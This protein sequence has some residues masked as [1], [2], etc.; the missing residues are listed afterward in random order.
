MIQMVTVQKRTDERHNI[1]ISVEKT[2][3]GMETT[4]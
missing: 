2:I 3:A 4:L 1:S